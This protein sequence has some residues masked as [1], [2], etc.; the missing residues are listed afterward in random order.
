VVQKGLYMT[1]DEDLIM[2]YNFILNIFLWS[3]V[4]LIPRRWSPTN[5]PNRFI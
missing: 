3:Y 5:C 2:I 1:Q 4:G